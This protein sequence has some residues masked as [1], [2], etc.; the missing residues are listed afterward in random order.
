MLMWMEGSSHQLSDT[1]F[2]HIDHVHISDFC[3]FNY[4]WFSYMRTLSAEFVCKHKIQNI[5]PISKLRSRASARYLPVSME[6]Y[7]EKC[8]ICD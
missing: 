7:Y 4:L 8:R 6:E 2:V 3:P 1:F 5:F